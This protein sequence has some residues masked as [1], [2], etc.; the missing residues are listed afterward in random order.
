[1]GASV[2]EQEKEVKSLD[3][4]S[5]VAE[6]FGRS[7]WVDYRPRTFTKEPGKGSISFRTVRLQGWLLGVKPRLKGPQP[8][9]LSLHH[10]HPRGNI[11]E[12]N[13]CAEALSFLRWIV[14][15]VATG[16]E[17]RENYPLGQ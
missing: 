16:G 12:S 3:A 13:Y 6:A 1:M 17:A 8:S 2:P 15:P 5:I 9:V 14:P 11:L 4:Q 7:V 10:S